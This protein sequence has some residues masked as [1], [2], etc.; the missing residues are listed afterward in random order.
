M[1]EKAKTRQKIAGEKL[2]DVYCF[3]AFERDTK[4]LLTW[5]LGRRTEEDTIIFVKKVLDA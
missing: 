3:T 4:L 5:H 2:G 1:K